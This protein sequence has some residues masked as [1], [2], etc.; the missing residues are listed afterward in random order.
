MIKY[1]NNLFPESNLPV[2]I[3]RAIISYMQPADAKALSQT[4]KAANLLV[5]Q[6]YETFTPRQKM[7]KRLSRAVVTL[8]NVI[9]KIEKQDQ[10]L[11]D[12]LNPLEEQF[13]AN[14]IWSKKPA[15][16]LM[17]VIRRIAMIACIITKSPA[18]LICGLAARATG[19]QDGII[20]RMKNTISA[21][22]T[23][24]KYGGERGKKDALYADWVFNSPRSEKPDAIEDHPEPA[25]LPE[26]KQLREQ[27]QR[28][29]RQLKEFKRNYDWFQEMGKQ[30]DKVCYV[31]WKEGESAET[32]IRLFQLFDTHR[33][34]FLAKPHLDIWIIL[35]VN[36]ESREIT[37]KYEKNAL[38]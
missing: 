8:K 35:E 2:E 23:I 18:V 21:I 22:Q 33:V 37:C 6:T 13:N 4:S 28:I 25:Q 5:N 20:M 16:F 36:E 31:E 29:E 10:D 1:T 38:G 32:K 24:W 12:R 17:Q 30:S 15:T 3:E 11:G 9:Y 34:L 14:G 26:M 7:I 19:S 27:R